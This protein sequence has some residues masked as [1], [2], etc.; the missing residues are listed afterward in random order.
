MLNYYEYYYCRSL[1]L[2]KW[3]VT[4]LCYIW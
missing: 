3:S 1:Q 2:L 4:S